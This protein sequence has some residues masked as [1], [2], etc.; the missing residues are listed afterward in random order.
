MKK[1]ILILISLA[2]FCIAFQRCQKQKYYYD[3]GLANA[4]Y[5]GDILQYLQN[6][7]YHMFDSLVKVIGL[8]GM[9]D[10]F[11]KDSITFFAMADTAIRH[12]VQFLNTALDAQGKDTITDLA[13]LS[14]AFWKE[15]LSLYLFVGIHR[16]SDYPQIDYSNLVAYG[17]GYYK[18][19]G[20]KVMNIGVVYNSAGDVQYQGY[21]QLYINYFSGDVPP[22]AFI[23]SV[24]VASSDINP[25][26]GIV[27][28]LQFTDQY[29]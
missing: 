22:S 25:T 4:K 9:N 23:Y 20:E 8:A 5:D 10:I 29:F 16:L 6:N 11:E 3:T 21:R 26:N 19:Y 2:F 17:G 1:N 15:E 12:S 24:P 7:Q 27:H 28:A 14:P 13:Q 18:S